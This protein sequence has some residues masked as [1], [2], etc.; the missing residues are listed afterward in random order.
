M[1]FSQM[2]LQDPIKESLAKNGYTEPTAIQEQVIELALTGKN[3]V[4]QSQTGTG[5][6][7]AFVIPL[8]ELIDGRVR[9]PQAIILAPTRELASQIREEVFKL[10]E[11]MKLRSAVIFG[12]TSFRKQ[13]E[14]LDQ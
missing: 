13:K 11:G 3:I 4:G 5:K 10:S 14:T 1:L 7:A 6:T 8:L 2:K 9:R 12:G